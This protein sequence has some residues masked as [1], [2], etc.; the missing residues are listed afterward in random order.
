MV[1]GVL[2]S[3]YAS[4]DHDLAHLGMTPIHWFPEIINWVIGGKKGSS[5]YVNFAK[6]LRKIVSFIVL[7]WEY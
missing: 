6:D 4:S 3:C 5:G 2:T 7:V 1:D